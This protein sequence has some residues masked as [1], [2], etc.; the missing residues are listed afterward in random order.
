M[1]SDCIASTTHCLYLCEKGEALRAPHPSFY[2]YGYV[3]APKVAAE[4]MI[5]A[6]EHLEFLFGNFDV[7]E[8]AKM[9]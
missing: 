6:V 2:G 4:L 3:V 1:D 9:G 8:I 5:H 7:V